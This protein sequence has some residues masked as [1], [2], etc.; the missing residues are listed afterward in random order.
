[1]KY[2]SVCTFPTDGLLVVEMGTPRGPPQFQTGGT[3]LRELRDPPTRKPAFLRK[4]VSSAAVLR[5]LLG[6]GTS[7]QSQPGPTRRRQGR[8]CLMRAPSPQHS[9]A[10]PGQPWG[11]RHMGR[12]RA[13]TG[14][15]APGAMKAAFATQ[16][17]P[18]QMA[19][20]LSGNKERHGS[21]L[22]EKLGNVRL[23]SNCECP[24]QQQRWIFV[25]VCAKS[26]KL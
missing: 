19:N 17:P 10:G 5:P 23:I 26:L 6:P 20:V 14:Q 22:H 7:G 25:C 12:Q 3:K 9:R 21:S 18:R 15:R 4:A 8:A 24:S 11:K 13:W 2:D 16:G 1:M